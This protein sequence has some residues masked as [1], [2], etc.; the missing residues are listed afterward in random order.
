MREAFVALSNILAE[1]AQVSAQLGAELRETTEPDKWGDVDPE[2]LAGVLAAQQ[3]LAD[4]IDQALCTMSAS[5]TTMD[6]EIGSTEAEV[7][8]LLEATDTFSEIYMGYKIRMA[9]RTGT[10]RPFAFLLSEIQQAFR[11]GV[12]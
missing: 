8:V 4:G 2:T 7:Q 12:L 1:T 11:L 9:S 6:L 10:V 3:H 5:E